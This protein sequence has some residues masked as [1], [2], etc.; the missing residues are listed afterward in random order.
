[1]L[2]VVIPVSLSPVGTRPMRRASVQP[3]IMVGA[4]T[5]LAA[6]TIQEP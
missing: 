4:V 2:R 3:R 6:R 5:R 1:M